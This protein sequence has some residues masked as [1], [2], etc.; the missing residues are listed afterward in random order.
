MAHDMTPAAK[1]PP[2][3]VACFVTPHGLG[4]AARTAAILA[5]LHRRLPMLE[6]ELY[7]L[8]PASFFE[9]SRIGPFAYHA[10]TTD[11]GMA[12]TTPFIE[13]LP[14]TLER[15]AHLLPF[16][17]GTVKKLA[18]SIRSR[19]CRAVLCDVAPLGLA[20]ARAAGLPSVLVEN[21]TWDWIYAGYVDEAPALQPYI[22]A[23]QTAFALADF[24]IQ[25]EPVCKRHPT[26]MQAGVV[27]R[28][29]RTSA[30]LVRK[31]L[32]IPPGTPAVL[33][34]SGAL[35]PAP[36]LLNA[37]REQP[38]ITF[39]FPGGAAGVVNGGNIRLLSADSEF[40]HPDLVHA[41]DAVVGKLGYS[42]LAEVYH[43]GVPF[44]YVTRPRFRE[45]LA[46]EAFVQAHMPCLALTAATLADGSW[47]AALPALLARPRIPREEP[48]GADVIADW[49]ASVVL[50]G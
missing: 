16:D 13:D 40:Y 9:E 50:G 28:P 17:S 43:A 48:N 10:F 44:A 19:G 21:F 2:L 35:C 41:C 46:L 20:V 32:G 24:H 37:M 7:T 1:L 18:D 12:Q 22:D 8:V 27:S 29:T 4:H 26:A 31:R 30:V 47:L 6:T 25:T 23:M 3:R 39:V 49:L 36:A 5:A 14:A 15:L 11:V 33:I 34:T 45:S 38:S 42:T